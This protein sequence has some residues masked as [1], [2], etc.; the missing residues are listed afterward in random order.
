MCVTLNNNLFSHFPG[1]I[2]NE[3]TIDSEN[4]VAVLLALV[5]SA[6]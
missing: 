5:K 1:T 2:H 4:W 6:G 3:N